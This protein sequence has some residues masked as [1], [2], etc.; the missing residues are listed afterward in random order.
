MD[1]LGIYKLSLLLVVGL[2]TKLVAS[3]N[4]NPPT[5][6]QL[7][8]TPNSTVPASPQ[9]TTA[10][11]ATEPFPYIIPIAVAAGATLGL[12]LIICIIICCIWRNR[13]KTS[14]DR[15][16]VRKESV[17][18]VNIVKRGDDNRVK[19]APRFKEDSNWNRPDLT[20]ST[21][22]DNGQVE[23]PSY[24]QGLYALPHKSAKAAVVTIETEEPQPP[25]HY[26]T[27][28]P[29]NETSPGKPLIR[30]NYE[31]AKL[32]NEGSTY[33][34]VAFTPDDV[35]DD[36]GSH[37]PDKNSP[38][39]GNRVRFAPDD[40]YTGRGS[41]DGGHSEQVTLREGLSEDRDKVISG[42]Y[43]KVNKQGVQLKEDPM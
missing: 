5:T 25:S 34:N 8:K 19:T 16:D 18:E 29:E 17:T 43:A 2:S 1:H 12:I 24:P 4:P 3:Q 22:D 35:S 10:A 9:P 13:G 36:E 40:E 7:T 38:P 37:D 41:P 20:P 14:I 11:S 32:S 26:E 42:M 39:G 28:S 30:Q 15:P 31:K 33:T 6:T 21:F 27:V 23:N